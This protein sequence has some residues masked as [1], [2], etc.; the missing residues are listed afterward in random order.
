MW[1]CHRG[2]DLS[3]GLSAIADVL[4]GADVGQQCID[5]GPSGTSGTERLHF[6]RAIAFNDPLLTMASV[7]YREF[8]SR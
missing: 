1:N 2:L 8:H 5:S 4:L 3:F 6:L 7:S